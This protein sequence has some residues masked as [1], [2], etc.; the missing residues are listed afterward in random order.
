MGGAGQLGILMPRTTPTPV[1]THT[2]G[3][4]DNTWNL[5]VQGMERTGKS[6]CTPLRELL[7]SRL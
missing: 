3:S 7:I 2:L 4:P 1:P 5:L 6:N